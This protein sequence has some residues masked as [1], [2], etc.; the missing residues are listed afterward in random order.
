M[1]TTK[2]G[3]KFRFQL[4]VNSYS[5]FHSER[6]RKLV[7]QTFWL[8][9]RMKLLGK[10]AVGTRS[11]YGMGCDGNGKEGMGMGG[12]VNQNNVAEHLT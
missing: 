3:T 2:I 7:V 6:K 4:I 8:S 12:N 9:V 1:L 11:D 5:D 10:M